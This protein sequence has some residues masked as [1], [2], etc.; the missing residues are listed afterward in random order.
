MPF[1][2]LTPV[3]VLVVLICGREV[4][5]VLVAFVSP[6]LLFLLCMCGRRQVCNMDAT[7]AASLLLGS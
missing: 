2:H 5:H 3:G 4:L 7:L 6:V 1:P